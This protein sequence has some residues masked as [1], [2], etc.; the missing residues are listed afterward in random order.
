[1]PIP[2]IGLF[3]VNGCYCVVGVKARIGIAFK[4]TAES[5]QTYDQSR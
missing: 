1:M 4:L 3:W 2:E 5:R